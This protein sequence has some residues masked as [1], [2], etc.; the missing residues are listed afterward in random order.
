[1]TAIPN[2]KLWEAGDAIEIVRNWIDDHDEEIRANEGAIPD[3]LAELLAQV[4]GTFKEKAERVALF[5]RELQ[6]TARAVK[7]EE[8]RLRD[9]RKTREAAADRLKRYLE[10]QMLD[11]MVPRIEGKLVTLRIQKNPPA[12]TH[13]LTDD[14]LRSAPEE[15][16]RVIPEQRT[17][18]REMVLAHWRMT[19]QSPIEGVEVS[20]GASLRIA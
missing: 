13:N 11:H 20:Q 19:G 14:D 6:A 15:F 12:V 3:E 4:E 17:L 8:D 9:R 1:M 5:V 16:V 18:N 10:A 2:I 7:E